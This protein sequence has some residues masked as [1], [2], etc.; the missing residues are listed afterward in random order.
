M[1]FV[2]I[3]IL[4]L[5][6]Y[7]GCFT[8]WCSHLH[9]I[10]RVG[11]EI[12]ISSKMD[13]ETDVL[14]WFKRCMFNNIFT[15]YRV[16]MLHND[17]ILPVSDP[18]SA[19]DKVLN[20]S[21]SDNIGPFDIE[22]G[23]WCGG[24]HSYIDGVTRTAVTESVAVFADGKK[25]ERDTLAYA[26]NVRIEVKNYIFNPVSAD[27]VGGITVFSDTLC[28]ES[29]EYDVCK[30]NI[31]VEVSHE[32]TN[33][34]P[35]RIARYYGMQSMFCGELAVLTPGGE[36]SRWTDI[37]RVSRF[38]KKRHG[39][40]RRF[41]EKNNYA[42]QSAYLFGYGLGSHTELTGNDVVFIGNSS[43]KCYH[44]LI[45]GKSREKGC[46]DSW[47]GVYTWFRK[48]LFEDKHFYIYEGAFEGHTA[49]YVSCNDTSSCVVELPPDLVNMKFKVVEPFSSTSVYKSGSN[50]I[51]ISSGKNGGCIIVFAD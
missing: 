6:L 35:V 40:F 9:V 25:V 24:N 15:F 48:P 2:K 36:Y 49:L 37:D 51:T 31:R 21:V 14:Y 26:D 1:R 20:L 5:T 4:F 33:T 8:A 29:V 46:A 34:I 42:C 50:N 23:G 11:E 17:N 39:N 7:Y 16:G 30:N 45:S 41:I 18:D 44:K 38:K 22:K 47:T 32:Y 43:G 28:M 19:P 27:T 10:K 12:F 3:L 13:G